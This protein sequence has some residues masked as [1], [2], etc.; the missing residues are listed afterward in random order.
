[1]WFDTAATEAAEHAEEAGHHTPIIVQL[2]NER[3]GEPVLRFQLTYTKPIWDKVLGWF[4][5][6]PEAAFGVP[7]TFWGHGAFLPGAPTV[8]NHNPTFA[9]AIQPTLRT[10]T[11]AAIAA[12]LAYV[13]KS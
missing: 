13:G 2:V 4:G 10:G 7:Y 5:T 9:P 8:A 11:E 12:T 3:F 1:M 6:T